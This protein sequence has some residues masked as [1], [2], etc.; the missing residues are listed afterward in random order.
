VVAVY[1]DYTGCAAQRRESDKGGIIVHNSYKV[2]CAVRNEPIQFARLQHGILG[3]ELLD[4]EMK[5]SID[6][7]QTDTTHLHRHE[8]V[9]HLFGTPDSK[10]F[11]SNPDSADVLSHAR[12]TIYSVSIIVCKA[13]HGGREIDIGAS[14]F[15]YTSKGTSLTASNNVMKD[16]VNLDIIGSQSGLLMMSE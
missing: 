5:F 2:L 14:L 12:D 13:K 8:I 6:T 15:P 3:C 10:G 7:P 16:L 11:A 9:Q 4:L 1:G